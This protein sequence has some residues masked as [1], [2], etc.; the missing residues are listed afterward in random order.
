MPLTG[1]PSGSHEGLISHAAGLNPP[2]VQGIYA[3]AYPSDSHFQLSGLL[4]EYICE[5]HWLG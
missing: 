4:C 3:V 5:G 2:A 1:T